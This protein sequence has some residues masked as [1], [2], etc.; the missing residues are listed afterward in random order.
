MSAM[1]Q[2]AAEAL[3]RE[4]GDM[5]EH[6]DGPLPPW[7]PVHP[8]NGMGAEYE[9]DGLALVRG[10]CARPIDADRAR[11]NAEPPRPT[12]PGSGSVELADVHAT[13]EHQPSGTWPGR[14]ASPAGS[15]AW[16]TDHRPTRDRAMAADAELRR[17][18][19][20]IRL[21]PLRQRHAPTR[22]GYPP[23]QAAA[24]PHA[25]PAPGRAHPGHRRR[26]RRRLYQPRDARHPTRPTWPSGAPNRPHRSRPTGGRA[27]KRRP[28]PA[29]STDAELAKYVGERQ[30]PE[31][32]AAP[33]SGP[34]RTGLAAPEA[35]M[36]KITER[37]S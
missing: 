24:D 10:E 13:L 32:R 34:D 18:H 11:R 21:E 37:C 30:E 5:T 20:D 35:R 14:S 28:A 6:T 22:T 26:S 29:R 33:E 12:R 25:S 8:R 19:P 17:R 7:R 15:D 36:D 4:P 31:T 3:D 23:H 1:W 27:P 2:A 9:G 16:E